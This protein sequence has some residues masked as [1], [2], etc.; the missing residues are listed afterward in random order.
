MNKYFQKPQM[1]LTEFFESLAL[2]N[3]G[4]HFDYNLIL[5][6]LENTSEKVT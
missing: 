4:S 2:Y 3:E 6:N 5:D 1:D